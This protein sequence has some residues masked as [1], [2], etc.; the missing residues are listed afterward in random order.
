MAEDHDMKEGEPL[1]SSAT[2]L[3]IKDCFPQGCRWKTLL[4]RFLKM[5]GETS[6]DW[7]PELWEEYGIT[8]E[9]AREIFKEYEKT[10]P[11]DV[12]S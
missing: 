4:I 1:P 11:E 9:E 5:Y 7:Y 8:V 10:Y 6:G 12:N 2:S 3:P